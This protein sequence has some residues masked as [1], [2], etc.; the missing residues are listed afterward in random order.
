MSDGLKSNQIHFSSVWQRLIY[1]ISMWDI[2]VL[3]CWTYS[4]GSVVSLYM[5]NI[6]SYISLL[7]FLW[8]F[9][10]CCQLDGFPLHR[11]SNESFLP[12]ISVFRTVPN[13]ETTVKGL[14]F[15]ETQM[16]TQMVWTIMLQYSCIKR[17]WPCWR[18][19]L[20][21]V[22]ASPS[23]D[24]N[25]RTSVLCYNPHLFPLGVTNTPSGGE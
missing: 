5:Q 23:C 14:Y 20:L 3:L 9:P 4:V 18:V 1:C 13:V 8:A 21:P 10:E 12:V 24:F 15:T 25:G 17:C 6:P 19:L 2:V 11:S 16:Y 7:V 22:V